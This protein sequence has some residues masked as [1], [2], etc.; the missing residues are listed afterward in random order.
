MKTCSKDCTPLCDFCIY[1]MDNAR[2][3]GEDIGCDGEGRC[4]KHNKDVDILDECED[5]YCFRCK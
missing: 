3:R 4:F 1:Y 2:L 5:F